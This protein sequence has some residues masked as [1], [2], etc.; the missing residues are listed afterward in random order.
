MTTPLHVLI[1][2]D[3]DAD[4]VLTARALR[5]G[6]YDAHCQRVDT[7]EALDEALQG[8]SWDVVLCDSAMP[9]LS[10]PAT[11]R[12]VQRQSPDVP[13][14]LLS[15]RRPE[16][17][18]DVLRTHPVGGLLAKDHLEDLPALLYTLMSPAR[19]H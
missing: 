16:E 11:V 12:R 5:K 19:S 18:V 17:L 2:D 14:V 10:I 7:P 1:V 13:V 6:G 9:C 8:H 15:G 4:A 3:S